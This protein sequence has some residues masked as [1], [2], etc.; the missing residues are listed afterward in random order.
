MRKNSYAAMAA[1]ALVAGTSA[2]KQVDNPDTKAVETGQSIT[3][4]V[5]VIDGMDTATQLI[6]QAGLEEMLQGEA[7]YTLFLP[8]DQAFSKLPDGEL[9][10]LSSDEGRPDLIALLRQHM[11]PGM[12]TQKDLEAGLDSS[13]GKVALATLAESPLSL[14]REGTKIIIGDADGAPQISLPPHVATNGVVYE[15][16]GLIPPQN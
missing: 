3:D 12:V 1:I 2:C 10:R 16:S 5:G 8:G 7:A 15:V 11:V 14:H 13:G 9:D 6:G 4:T